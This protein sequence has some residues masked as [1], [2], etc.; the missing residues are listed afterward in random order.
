M[1]LKAVFFCTAHEPRRVSSESGEFSQGHDQR[2]SRRIVTA[3]PTDGRL[4]PSYRQK[5]S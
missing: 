1:H 3:I 5:G 2:G 4:Q